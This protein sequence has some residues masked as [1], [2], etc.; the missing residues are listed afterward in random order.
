VRAW[1]LSGLESR[2]DES[3]GKDEEGR[4]GG[5]GGEGEEADVVAVA[6]V[7]GPA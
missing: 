7:I 6:V 5:R 4:R 2:G 3:L 1:D